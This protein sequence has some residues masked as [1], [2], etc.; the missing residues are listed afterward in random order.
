MPLDDLTHLDDTALP[1][2]KIPIGLALLCISTII[3]SFI[4]IG[5]HWNLYGELEGILSG[6][7]NW[8]EDRQILI[9]R[10]HTL[11]QLSAA[12]VR[13]VAAFLLLFRKLLGL[14]L[15]LMACGIAI[16]MEIKWG[17]DLSYLL[18]S[19]GLSIFMLLGYTYYYLQHAGYKDKPA[20]QASKSK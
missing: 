7:G 6:V 12:A 2:I 16:Y 10:D 18:F 19:G 1:S 17:F 11:L 8:V 13:I 4:S 5:Y 14:L 15:Y 9:L 20:N 3:G